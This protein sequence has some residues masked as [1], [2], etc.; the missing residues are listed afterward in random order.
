MRVH[1]CAAIV[2]QAANGAQIPAGPVAVGQF[3]LLAS[4]SVQTF[5]LLY[6]SNMLRKM[7]KR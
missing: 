2:K 3:D 6:L 4:E 5:V 7:K 1:Q